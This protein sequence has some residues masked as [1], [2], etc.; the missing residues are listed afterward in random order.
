MVIAWRP[1][2]AWPVWQV[3]AVIHFDNKEDVLV[4]W[5][6]QIQVRY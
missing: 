3:E 5:D 6:A 2:P 4:Q 1:C